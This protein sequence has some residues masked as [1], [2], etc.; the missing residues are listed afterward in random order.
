MGTD[1]SRSSTPNYGDAPETPKG[2]WGI[3]TLGM[4]GA[5]ISLFAGV[6]GLLAGAISVP[7]GGLLI[8]LGIAQG[9]TMLALVGLT[10]WA[11]YA[12]ILL[13][14]LSGG[15]NLLQGDGIGMVVSLTVVAYVGVHRD[16]FEH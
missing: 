8:A 11:W 10:L 13:Y 16:L 7:A 15:I 5:V 3:A 6:N 12:T 14:L 4:I 9:I 1:R 2:I